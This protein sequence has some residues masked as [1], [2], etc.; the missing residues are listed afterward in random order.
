[1]S[2]ITEEKDNRVA[3]KVTV[4]HYLYVKKQSA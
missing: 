3:K 1:M 4:G 2:Q